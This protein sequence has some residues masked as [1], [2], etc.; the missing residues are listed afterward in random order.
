MITMEQSANT[1]LCYSSNIPCRLKG[2]HS[3]YYV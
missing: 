2:L 3:T 1:F